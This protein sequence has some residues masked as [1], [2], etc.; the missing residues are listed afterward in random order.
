MVIEAMVGGV[1]Q[2]AVKGL[3]TAVR[4]R[5]RP[6]VRVLVRPSPQLYQSSAISSVL[7]IGVPAYTLVLHPRG[8]RP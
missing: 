5:E 4:E 3:T 1:L 7:N 8:R 6:R 2:S